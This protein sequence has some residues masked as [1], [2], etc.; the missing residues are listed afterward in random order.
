MEKR[1][2]GLSGIEVVPL[3]LGGNVFGWTADEKTFRAAGRLC[4]RRVS[5]S[6]IR[7]MFIRSGCPA[8]TAAKAK[9]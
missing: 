1:K 8:M 9:A 6:S 2:L 4:R 7:R 5:V 3:C